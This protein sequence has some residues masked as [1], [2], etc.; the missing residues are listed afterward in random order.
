MLGQ[1]SGAGPAPGSGRYFAVSA[2]RLSNA[3][4]DFIR[5]RRSARC[6]APAFGASA[7]LELEAA[8]NWW[9]PGAVVVRCGAGVEWIAFRCRCD[10]RAGLLWMRACTGSHGWHSHIKRHPHRLWPRNRRWW[11][12]MQTLAVAAGREG[13]RHPRRRFSR[14]AEERLCEWFGSNWSDAALYRHSSRNM[15]L[16]RRVAAATCKARFCRGPGSDGVGRRM[17]PFMHARVGFAASPWCVAANRTRERE[18][19]RSCYES[20][21]RQEPWPLE[22]QEDRSPMTEVGGFLEDSPASVGEIP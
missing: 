19:T 11:R 1:H 13:R 3:C 18:S 10:A 8:E 22:M 5:R 7:S 16:S 17:R 20:D 4:S 12:T 15:H 14:P 2:P 21:G 6:M 9:L